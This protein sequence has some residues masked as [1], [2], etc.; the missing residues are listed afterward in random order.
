VLL[1]ITVTGAKIVLL[2]FIEATNLVSQSIQK[3]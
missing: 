1:D 2:D 3:E